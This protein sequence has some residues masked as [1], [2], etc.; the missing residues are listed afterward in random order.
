MA[1]A[2]AIN[3][4]DI[5][6]QVLDLVANRAGVEVSLLGDDTDIFRDAGIGNDFQIDYQD[7]VYDLVGDLIREFDV[8]WLDMRWE[9]HFPDTGEPIRFSKIPELVGSFFFFVFLIL[10]LPVALIWPR[11]YGFL[12]ITTDGP[13]QKLPEP[14][15]ADL[16]PDDYIAIT[17]ADLVRVAEH[18]LWECRYDSSDGDPHQPT[19][20]PR[21]LDEFLRQHRSRYG[22]DAEKTARQVVDFVAEWCGIEPTQCREDMDLHRKLGLGAGLARWAGSFTDYEA[23]FRAYR[24]KFEVAIQ[25]IDYRR[26]FPAAF[27]WQYWRLVWAFPCYLLAIPFRFF[28]PDAT[29]RSKQWLFR[30]LDRMIWKHGRR[31]SEHRRVAPEYLGITVADLIRAAQLGLWRPERDRDS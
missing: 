18:R 9:R 21:H 28:F 2:G 20:N 12:G 4:N 25:D 22:D 31:W 30:R 26:H 1:P 11:V 24:A 10:L 6:A 14:V 5:R 16:L 23:F 17:V 29:E 7:D 8:Y 27:A 3:R 15:A 19:I 13:L